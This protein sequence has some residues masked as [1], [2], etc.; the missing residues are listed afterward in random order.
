MSEI[1]FSQFGGLLCQNRPAIKDRSF[2]R[3][4]NHF[5]T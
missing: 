2:G 4:W 3:I 1:D 5:P